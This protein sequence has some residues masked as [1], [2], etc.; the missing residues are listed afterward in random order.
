ML[1]MTV[2]EYLSDIIRDYIMEKFAYSYKG[3]VDIIKTR[4]FLIEINFL[5]NLIF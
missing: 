3:I 1:P 4:R 2:N 5:I